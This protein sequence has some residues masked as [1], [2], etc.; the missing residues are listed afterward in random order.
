MQLRVPVQNPDGSPTMPTKPGRAR[1]WVREG[2]AVG[3]WNDSGIYFVRLVAEPSGQEIQPIV[4]GIDPGKFYTG[5]AVQSAKFTLYLAHPVLPFQRVKER[6]GAAVIKN[7]KV[8]KNVRGRALQRRVRRGRRIKRKVAFKLRAHR[9]K[10]FSN[11]VKSKVAPSIKAS[12]LS[13]SLLELAQA[14]PRIP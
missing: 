13:D 14:R 6:L 7:G 2:K 4:I 11:R 12:R 1:R 9:Q 8:I 5:I 3:M 10:R